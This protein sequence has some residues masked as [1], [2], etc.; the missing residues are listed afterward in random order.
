MEALTKEF[1]KH[2]TEQAT[3]DVSR[4]VCKGKTVMPSTFTQTLRNA[5]YWETTGAPIRKSIAINHQ[6][7]HGTSNNAEHQFGLSLKNQSH[8]S[9][10]L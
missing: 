9:G 5:I 3:T 7:S 1:R 2:I 10:Q 6:V 8:V 4:D